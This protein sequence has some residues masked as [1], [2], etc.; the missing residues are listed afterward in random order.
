MYDVTKG[1]ILIDGKDVRK[2]DLA[3]LRKKIGYV[4]QDLFLFSDT[5]AGNIAF[6]KRSASRATI[7]EFSHYAAVY[8]DIAG[9]PEGFDTAV[10]ERG[11]TLSGGQKQRI[12]IAR[13]LIKEPD[14]VILDDCLSAVDT[15]TEQQILGYLNGKLKDKT[16]LIIT[17][18]IYSSLQFDHIIVLKD[19]Y[20]FEQ[21]THESLLEKEGYYAQVFEQQQLEDAT[22]S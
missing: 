2:H 1:E 5:I 21:G 10:G 20:I 17:H 13:A 15:T 9:L 18:R 4:P 19:G 3:N 8:D 11:V 12:S 6:G 16:S 7:E 14:I 22:K